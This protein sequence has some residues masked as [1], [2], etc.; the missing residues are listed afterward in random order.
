MKNSYQ[1]YLRFCVNY[2]FNNTKDNI[3]GYVLGINEK[4]QKKEIE[5]MLTTAEYMIISA[6]GLFEE[7]V[8]MIKAAKI[9]NAECQY[10]F[11]TS[12]EII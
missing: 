11:S 10:W 12:I 6:G 5:K 3:K 9:L 1:E 8:N 7:G 2:V 4:E